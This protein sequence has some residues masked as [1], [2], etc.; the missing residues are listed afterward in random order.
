MLEALRPFWYPVVRDADISK[1]PQRHMLLGEPLVIWRPATGEPVVA[2]KDLCIHRGAPLSSGSVA[3]GEIRCPYHG[4]RYNAEGVCTHIPA[5]PA[6][7]PV[8]GKARALRHHARTAYGLVW[9]CLA[10]VAEPFPDFLSSVWDDPAYRSVYVSRY[11]WNAAAAR[12]AENAMDFSHFNFVHKGYTEL[13][14]GPVIKPHEVLRN[15]RRLNYAYD[16]GHLLREYVV[17]FPF[18]VHDRKRVVNPGGGVTWSDGDKARSGD[19]T[20]LSFLST[21]VEAA[22][23]HIHV[24]VTRNHAL[25]SDDSEF[26]KGFDVVMEQDR[27][28]VEMQRPEQVPV[29]ISEELHLRLPDQA[30]VAYRR[31]LRELGLPAQMLP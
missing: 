18:L 3:D 28:I 30:S 10:D 25:D 8:P 15:D 21:P 23:T 16:D 24:L 26:T 12:V 31:M 4:W 7:A 20:L 19:I 6:G 9:V 13:A 5:L 27:V 29:D 14:D 17:E 11:D 22:K 2:M 1:D